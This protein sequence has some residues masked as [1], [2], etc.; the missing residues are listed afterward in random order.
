[1]AISVRR[2]ALGTALFFL[3]AYS[4]TTIQAAEIKALIT[5]GV[6]SAIEELA[7]KF[8]KASGHRLTIVY[9]LSAALSKR[10]VDGEPLDLFIGTRKDIDGLMKTGMISTGSDVT[11]ASSRVGIAVRAGVPKPDISTP[12]ALKRTLLA[13][14]AIGYG[15]PAAG[16][17]AGVH[18][19]K[20]I[21]H[22][23]IVEEMKSK[24][25][26]PPA[27]GYTASMLVSGE[28]DLAV[29]QI[30]ELTFV[31]GVELVGPLPGDLNTI[32]VL[33]AGIA[34]SASE[35]NAAGALIG[36]LRSP[37]AVSIFKAKG[38]DPG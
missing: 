25:R 9:G 10:I 1:M 16:G 7:P 32:T 37:E 35:P 38:L 11:I 36:F 6:Q 19:A 34:A 13:A 24:T 12:D 20:V 28:V 14:R 33:A 8:E 30:P 15:N 29:Q 2:I 3:A 4:S 18:F 22:L 26:F 5:I 17:A 27:G 23:G 21:E 31:R